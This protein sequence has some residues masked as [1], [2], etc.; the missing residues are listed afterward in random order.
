MNRKFIG[1]SAAVRED[2]INHLTESEQ[3]EFIKTVAI[4]LE[5][6][7]RMM[8]ADARPLGDLVF[9]VQGPFEDPIQGRIHTHILAGWFDLDRLPTDCLAYKTYVGPER[10]VLPIQRPDGLMDGVSLN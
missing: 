1:V 7:L 5:A 8:V 2:Q 6:E 3:D 4:R 10:A 9:Q